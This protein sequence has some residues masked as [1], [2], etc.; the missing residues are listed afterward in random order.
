MDLTFC[1]TDLSP[2][3]ERTIGESPVAFV[4]HKRNLSKIAGLRSPATFGPIA[5]EAVHCAKCAKE[6]R[7]YC[8]ARSNHIGDVV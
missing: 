3:G 6:S 7:T 1:T 8:F 5:T 4:Y 2:N